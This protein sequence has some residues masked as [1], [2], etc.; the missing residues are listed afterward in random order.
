MSSFWKG[1]FINYSLFKNEK[2]NNTSKIEKTKYMVTRSRKSI[3]LPLLNNK[4]LKVY[5]G[6]KFFL[7]NISLYNVGYKIG[8]FIRSK[9]L[10][11]FPKKEKKKKKK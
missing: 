5:N 10:C 7:L 1:P 6:N 9:K 8:D 2:I 3:I 11:V 4:T